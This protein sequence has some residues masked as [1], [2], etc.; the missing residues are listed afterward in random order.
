MRERE[1][2]RERERGRGRERER[3]REERGERERERELTKI[4]NGHIYFRVISLNLHTISL[5]ED[6]VYVYVL[7][8]H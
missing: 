4:S 3:E 2:A 6:F 7:P 1:R 8:K 5:T